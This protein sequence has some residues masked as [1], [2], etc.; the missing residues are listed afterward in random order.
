MAYLP[1]VVIEEWDAWAPGLTLKE[2]WKNWALN[3]YSLTQ[4]ERI[5]T[6]NIPPII[7]RRCS[8]L[9]KIFLDL[10]INVSRNRVI[11][12]SVFCSQHGE[13]DHSIK[14]LNNICENED[15]S[16]MTFVQSVHNT[17][18]GLFT[19]I[20]NIKDSS[21]SIASGPSTFIS[22][23]I[24][25]VSWLQT[26]PDKQVLLVMADTLVPRVYSSLVSD[27]K[28]PYGLS[29]LLRLS[30]KGEAKTIQGSILKSKRDTICKE[31]PVGLEFL[32]WFL[33][34]KNSLDQAGSSFSIVWEKVVG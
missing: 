3:P 6:K 15:L 1:K 21:T 10:A 7:K 14:L 29:L 9:S 26:N 31:L 13:L 30:K 20:E 2:D 16:P 17:S 8:E 24:E 22:G 23:F 27:T 12:Y 5:I 18:S 11:D 25:A 19:I 34:D 33:S 4:G 28:Y 32:Q